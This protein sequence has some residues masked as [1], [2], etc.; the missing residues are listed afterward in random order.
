MTDGPADQPEHAAAPGSG[1]TLDCEILRH[2]PVVLWKGHDGSS[3][4]LMVWRWPAAAL[5]RATA[6]GVMALGALLAEPGH[7]AI[8]SVRHASVTDEAALLAYRTPGEMA[9]AQW[10]TEH[11]ASVEDTLRAAIDLVA[12]IEACRK[13]GVRVAAWDPARL[14]VRE[15]GGWLLPSPGIPGLVG[16]ERGLEPTTVTEAAACAPELATGAR[17][18]GIAPAPSV[19]TE[20]YALGATLIFALCRRLPFEAGT[21]ADTLRRQLEGEAPRLAELDRQYTHFERLGAFIADCLRRAP[22]QR[23]Q[24]TGDL[25]R[26]LQEALDEARQLTKNGT[27]L[28]ARL[29]DTMQ[30]RVN[31]LDDRREDAEYTTPG[32]ARMIA[33]L[34]LIVALL[35][36][37]LVFD[38]RGRCHEAGG[39]DDPSAPGRPLGLLRGPGSPP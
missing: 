15:R 34:V 36:F 22:E 39:S 13:L 16:S 28:P 1:L 9:L 2:G 12:G 31:R 26:G 27:F 14:Q 20:A 5:S 29:T 8:G 6:D 23:P 18:L 19:S 11:Q 4:Q 35:F 3:A 30:I 33:A 21:P 25:T 32:R 7:P 17:A 38:A 10:L 24:T 37:L